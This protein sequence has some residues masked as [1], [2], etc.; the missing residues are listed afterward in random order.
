M[1]RVEELIPKALEAAKMLEENGAINKA[2]NGYIATFGASIRQ[3][4]L[5]PTILFFS[6]ESDSTKADRT[7]ILRAIEQILGV[8]KEQLPTFA[9]RDPKAKEKIIDAAVALKLAIRAF[10]L[11]DEE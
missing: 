1:K 5:L 7:K 3:A 4:G 6:K 2:Y 10:K 9:Q 11:K 8:P